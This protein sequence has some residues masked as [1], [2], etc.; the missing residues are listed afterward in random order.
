MGLI[1]VLFVEMSIMGID[2]ET[3]KQL[4][5]DEE[6]VVSKKKQLFQ[7]KETIVSKKKQLFQRKQLFQC[8]VM[9]YHCVR[10]Q[11]RFCSCMNDLVTI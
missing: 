11:K 7:D 9:T 10:S 2:V 4:F 3:E 5:Q 8:K 1:T 6:T